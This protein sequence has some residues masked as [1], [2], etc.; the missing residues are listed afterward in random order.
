MK[1][2][3]KLYK[4]FF[5]VHYTVHLFNELEPNWQIREW[6]DFQKY[7]YHTLLQPGTRS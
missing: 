3:L 1:W 5:T 2:N 7:Q 4:N 6:L